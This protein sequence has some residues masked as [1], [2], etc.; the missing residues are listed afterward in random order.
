[1]M[2]HG[3]IS[4]AQ[5]KS[6]SGNMWHIPVFGMYIMYFLSLIEI[7]NDHQKVKRNHVFSVETDSDDE[8]LRTPPK[9]RKVNEYEWRDHATG[10]KQRDPDRLTYGL[11]RLSFE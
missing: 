10:V 9:R 7:R 6:M 1:M 5:V 8:D 4:P 11:P 3:D 2:L